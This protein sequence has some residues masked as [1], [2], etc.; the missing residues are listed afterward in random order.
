MSCCSWTDV[1]TAML[2]MIVLQRRKIGKVEYGCPFPQIEIV[3]EWLGWQS[4]VCYQT[5]IWLQL[6]YLTSASRV[7]MAIPDTMERLCGNFAN[8]HTVS[9]EWVIYNVGD[10]LFITWGHMCP[11]HP[12]EG[13]PEI[14]AR[15]W[16]YEPNYKLREFY[17]TLSESHALPHRAHCISF[18]Y[19]HCQ[20]LLWIEAESEPGLAG[21][22]TA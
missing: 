11:S 13:A 3:M 18:N 6:G 20:L 14:N 5:V 17:K 2:E 15:A 19:R 4:E 16:K 12:K 21:R 8:L 9:A 10:I 22:G 1:G 7:L